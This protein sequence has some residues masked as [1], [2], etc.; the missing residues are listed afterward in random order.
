MNIT[1]G[2]VFWE[3]EMHIKY[4]YPYLTEDKSC[5]IL[6]IGGGI[7]GAISAYYQAK[8]GYKVIIVEKNLIGF[9]STLE[10]IGAVYS[11]PDFQNYVKKSQNEIKR[12]N[13]LISCAQK[14]L[15]EII[16]E[17]SKEESELKYSECNFLNFSQRASGRFTLSKLYD[18]EQSR[19]YA[20]SMVEQNTILD[21]YSALEYKNKAVIFNPYIL[22]QELIYMLNNMS[23]V[24]VYENTCV[25]SI[26]SKEHEVEA[27]TTNRFKIHASKVIIATGVDLVKY[28]KEDLVELYKTYNIVAKLPKS[29]NDTNFVAKENNSDILLRISNGYVIANGEDI[30]KTIR[31]SDEIYEE[32]FA[33]GK[34]KKLYN[35]LLKL[36][37]EENIKIKNCFYGM[38]LLT[39]DGLPI[40]DE[41]EQ[42]P[43]VYCNLGVGKN[44]ILH[45]IIGAKMHKNIYNDCYTKDMYMFRI[46]R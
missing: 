20:V 35:Y 42:M 14:D 11:K 30:K 25:E 17:V 24:E 38:Y 13:E 29:A 28:L 16:E 8:Q 45:N 39:N 34:Y 9:N 15:I 18:E 6:I 37:N 2:N 33:N 31:N 43:N 41:I 1:Q 7:A 21:I 32:R 3:D 12:L 23:N 44:G 36:L 5:D 46:N 4:S 26:N 27:Q 22:N 40:I 19:N 10:N